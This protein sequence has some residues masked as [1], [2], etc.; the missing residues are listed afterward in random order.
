MFLPL[1]NIYCSSKDTKSMSNCIIMFI[2][3]SLC[4]FDQLMYYNFY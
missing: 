1:S 3:R 4:H 2:I